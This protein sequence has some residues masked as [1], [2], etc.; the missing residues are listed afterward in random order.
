[1]ECRLEGRSEP[2]AGL[3]V[4]A[5]PQGRVRAKLTGAPLG[6]ALRASGAT[7]AEIAAGDGFV[8]HGFVDLRRF[9]AY[10]RRPVAV[11]EEH[12]SIA[13]GQRVKPL[14]AHGARAHIELSVPISGQR[15]ETWT[16][17]DDL[18]L[19]PVSGRGWD[20]PGDARGYVAEAASTRLYASPNTAP[21]FTFERGASPTGLLFF[22]VETR[23]DWVRL[24]RESA[25]SI[26]AWAR[27]S[28][29]RAL[30]EGERI[31]QLAPPRSSRSAA[32]VLRGDLRL[33][34]TR[35]ASAVRA[36][37]KNDGLIVGTIAANVEAYV[38]DVVL[39]WRRLLPKSLA[40]T[41]GDAGGF[42]VAPQ[43][44]EP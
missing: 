37:P 26:D 8:I 6:V 28:E 2:P 31:D 18:T 29:L 39:G 41:E 44:F 32:R 30:P 16:R 34:K 12:V 15:V 14:G 11:V 5:T 10:T 27:Q 25:L 3:E 33:A 42:W 36:V 7:R 9:E 13:Q 1:M 38:V 43:A 20:P 24:R 17:C 40:F 23:G 4:L 22:G 19:S 21:V 35:R